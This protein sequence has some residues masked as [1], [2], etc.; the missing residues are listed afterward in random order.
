MVWERNRDRQRNGESGCNFGGVQ[1]RIL[2]G[3]F[4]AFARLTSLAESS[5]VSW[6]CIPSKLGQSDARLAVPRKCTK[7]KQCLS[8][9]FVAFSPLPIRCSIP[10]YRTRLLLACIPHAILHLRHPNF[11]FHFPSL[12]HPRPPGCPRPLPASQPSSPRAAMSVPHSAHWP[13]YQYGFGNEFSSE[14]L[15]GALPRHNNPHKCPYS[16][17]AEQIS[18][19]AFTVPRSCNRR[20]WM[21][22]IR[23]TASQDTVVPA[24]DLARMVAVP[25]HVTPERLRWSPIPINDSLNDAHTFVEG[26]ITMAGAGDPADRNG[27]LSHR[28][29][30]RVVPVLPPS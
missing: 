18:G 25:D 3:K 14:A 21:Y 29:S 7:G 15:P 28:L 10:L 8:S 23:P 26:L 16:L 17:Y 5:R 20:T 11:I 13:H 1:Y 27:I 9:C 4:F 2:L 19:T 12:S 22:R 30:M 24:P 6:Q